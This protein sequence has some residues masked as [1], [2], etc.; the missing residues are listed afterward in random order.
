M[1]I[2]LKGGTL[3]DGSGNTPENN[4]AIL[5]N[6]KYIEK[7]GRL[8]DIEFD[9]NAIKIID[10]SGKTIMPGLINMHE[11]LTY[12]EAL[13]NPMHFMEK[14][15]IQGL[16]IFGVK[17]L[18]KGLR[19]GFT[20]VREMGSMHSIAL[21]LRDKV[22]TGEIPGPR[23][24]ACNKPISCT[25]GHAAV[26]NS[27]ADG[28][29]AVR[30]AAREQMNLGADFVK[31]MA[32]HDPWP[33]PGDQKTRAE[34][35][36]EELSAAFEEAH[37]WGKRTA[38]HCMGEIA[39][40]NVIEA[41]IDVIDHGIYLNDELA[42]L[43][44]E[45]GIYLTPTFSAYHKQTLNPKYSRGTEWVKD[46][47]PLAEAQVNS[48]RAAIKAGVKI[49]NGTD[50]VGNYA[51]EVELLRREGMDPMKSL[52][53]CTSWA[54]EALGWEDKIGTVEP[55]KIADIVILGGNPLDDPYALEKVEIVIKE[56]KVFDPNNIHLPL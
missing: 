40:R 2:I 17:T 38:C 21:Y 37:K 34:F 33:M 32:S 42:S 11:H 5:L 14:E 51:E 16:T 6:G 56:G 31:V 26:L 30:K 53:A 27:I 25:G 29:D 35:T 3:I 4:T 50:S 36:F 48:V 45:K 15:S 47:T 8:E 55:N 41:G 20:T 49:V 52:L 23:V 43:M 24:M 13:G 54:A 44:V 22:E 12:R 1:K 10:V 46:H 9:S 39:L 7:V 28:P 18:L 19:S